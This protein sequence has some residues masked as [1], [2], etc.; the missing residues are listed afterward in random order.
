MLSTFIAGRVPGS[1]VPLLCAVP[2]PQEFRAQQESGACC[3]TL[4]QEGALMC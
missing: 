4:L 3:G 2:L 1:A